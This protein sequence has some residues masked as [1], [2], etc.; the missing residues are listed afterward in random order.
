MAFQVLVE[1]TQAPAHLAVVASLALAAVGQAYQAA[2]P[3]E[4]PSSSVAAPGMAVVEPQA[5]QQTEQ[6]YLW[7]GVGRP[8]GAGLGNPASAPAAEGG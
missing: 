7:V 2:S 8:T 4:G 5:S 3:A 1:Q 6:A